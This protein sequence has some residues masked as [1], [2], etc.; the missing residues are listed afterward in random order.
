MSPT[1]EALDGGSSFKNRQGA[2]HGS[3]A[4]GSQMIDASI[5]QAPKQ[6]L[7][8]VHRLR[9]HHPHLSESR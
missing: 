2:K 3:I 1:S 9:S 4:R 7:S 5:V 6:S 8:K